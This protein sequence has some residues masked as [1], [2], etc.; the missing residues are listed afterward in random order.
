MS[1]ARSRSIRPAR[2]V[3]RLRHDARP[4]R[5]ATAVDA[6]STDGG[7]TDGGSPDGGDPPAEHRRRARR[8]VQPDVDRDLPARRPRLRV[9]RA[10]APAILSFA[11]T[12]STVT[13]LDGDR[14]ARDAAGEQPDPPRR[15][16]LGR[17][18]RPT[19]RAEFV[20]DDDEDREYL[21]VIAR[22]GSLRIV[23]VFNPGHE[24]GVRDE[25]RSAQSADQSGHRQVD[26]TPA[27]ACIPYGGREAP[28]VLDRQHRRPAL[29][30]HPGRRRGRQPVGRQR[31]KTPSTAATPG[32]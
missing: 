6:C 19:T 15:R 32:C 24:T 28:A 30:D 26:V 31:G 22:D 1:D 12:P 11:L 2:R 13:P 20:G 4:T 25:L 27:N 9:A 8:H 21:Y 17:P 14:A 5:A 10:P 18:D 16:S 29:P 3:G 7:S 23:D